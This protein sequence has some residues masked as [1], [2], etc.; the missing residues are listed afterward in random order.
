MI[1]MHCELQGIKFNVF[2]ESSQGPDEAQCLL[3]K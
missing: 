2:D 3:D 1:L